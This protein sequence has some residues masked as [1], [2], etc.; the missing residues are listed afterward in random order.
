MVMNTPVYPVNLRR[1]A[2]ILSSLS[3]KISPKMASV[4]YFGSLWMTFSEE[5]QDQI[6]ACLQRTYICII[7]A[8]HRMI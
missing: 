7:Y 8:S 4:R 6:C 2:I 5:L 3:V 1:V